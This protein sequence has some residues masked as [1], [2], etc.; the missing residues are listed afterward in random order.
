M[1]KIRR[2]YAHEYIHMSLLQIC[3]REHQSNKEYDTANPLILVA[4]ARVGDITMVMIQHTCKSAGIAIL[5]HTV[6]P[7]ERV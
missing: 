2:V 7:Q 1:L 3:D 5:T 6:N 4:T